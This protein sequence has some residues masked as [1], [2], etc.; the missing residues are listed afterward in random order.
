MMV[1]VAIG[2]RAILQRPAQVSPLRYAA[3]AVVPECSEY[4]RRAAGGSSPGPSVPDAA[5]SL[6]S[7]VARSW[8]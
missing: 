4:G 6:S 7:A 2:D 8:C 3:K 1:K 5:R